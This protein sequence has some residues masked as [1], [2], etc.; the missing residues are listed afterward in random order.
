MASFTINPP[1]KDFMS[2]E[3]KNI[4]HDIKKI[5]FTRKSS[6]SSNK[7]IAPSPPP[8]LPE[9][10]PKRTTSAQSCVTTS[11][12]QQK[13]QKCIEYL[14]S[15]HEF[16]LSKLHQE[17]HDLKSENKKL[18]FKIHLESNNPDGGVQSIVRKTLGSKSSSK[19]K[20]SEELLLQETIKDLQVKL[21]LS[22][23][24]NQH[25]EKTIKNLNKNLKLLQNGSGEVSKPVKKKIIRKTETPCRSPRPT[26]PPPLKNEHIEKDK[27]IL[28]LKDQNKLLLNRIEEQQEFI[29]KLQFEAK[30]AKIETSKHDSNNNILSSNNSN[31]NIHIHHSD[32]R[33][34]FNPMTSLPPINTFSRSQQNSRSGREP[35]SLTPRTSRTDISRRTRRK[36]EKF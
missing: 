18:N 10:H 4:P 25:L 32:S 3:R 17:V 6:L 24:T 15:Q 16:T 1:L 34:L 28:A 13:Y 8:P 29:K 14:Q 30:A 33:I 21:E 22:E 20:F 27:L 31:E 9:L 5:H 35:G 19:H 11:K 12:E 36:D 26:P 2:L 7:P 23:D